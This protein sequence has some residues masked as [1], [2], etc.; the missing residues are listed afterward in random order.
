MS[1]Y[2]YMEPFMCQRLSVSNLATFLTIL[3]NFFSNRLQQQALSSCTGSSQP[4]NCNESLT[5]SKM[6]RIFVFVCICLWMAVWVF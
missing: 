3:A 6:H 5:N 1:F 4:N 2:Y